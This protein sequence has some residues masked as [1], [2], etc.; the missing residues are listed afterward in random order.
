MLE[1][2]ALA[3]ALVAIDGDSIRCG[4]DRIRLVAASG[5]VDA[6]EMQHRRGRWN[7]GALAEKA[8][9]RLAVLIVGGVLHC[10]G[11]DQYRRRLCRV[12]VNGRDVGDMMVREK[13]AVI[14]EDWR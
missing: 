5:P 12:T 2:V 3:C 10:N 14:R 9:Q 13:L 11:H 1:A 7:D 8:R 4:T 6:P